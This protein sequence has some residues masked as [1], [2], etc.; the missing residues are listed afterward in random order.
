MCQNV[1]RDTYRCVNCCKT[2]DSYSGEEEMLRHHS[3]FY[4]WV[5]IKKI[6]EFDWVILRPGYGHIEMNMFKSFVNLNWDVFMSDLAGLMGFCSENAQKAA[7][8]CTDNHKTWTLIQ[9][10]YE[11]NLKEFDI[12]ATPEGFIKFVTTTASSPNYIYMALMTLTYLQAIMNMRAGL[13]RGN[14]CAFAPLFHARNHPKN[15]EIEM[16]EAIQRACVP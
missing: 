5:N 9:V 11:G 3:E 8:N 16:M 14:I 1:I 7:K 12:A 13:R 6:R 15:R 4:P 10:A 2:E